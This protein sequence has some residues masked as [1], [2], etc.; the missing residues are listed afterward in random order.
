MRALFG[1]AASAIALCAACLGNGAADSLRVVV[2]I[3][4]VSGIVQPLLPAGSTVKVLMAP[5]RSEHNYEFTPADMAAVGGADLVVFVGAGLEPQVAKFLASH[6]SPKRV[7]LNLAD[8]SGIKLE[9]ED[10]HDHKHEDSDH[11]H[12]GMDP[13]VW[14]DPVLVKEALPR[15]AKA[16]QAAM[17]SR[18]EWNDGAKQRLDEALS[19][20]LKQ[21]DELNRAYQ[22]RLG[23]FK[24]EKIVTHHAAF[25]RLAARYGLVVAEVIRMNEG[26]EP[27]PGRIA[28]IVQA[29]RNEGVRT[30]FVEP[31]FDGATAERI[32]KAAGVKVVTMDPLGD[33]D[34][35]AMMRGNLDALMKGLHP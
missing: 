33:G 25:G 31:Q 29:V 35:F 6:P 34:W 18:G 9:D 3:P 27:T 17:E 4:P 16:V 30:I 26:E 15:L 32:A 5:G 23:P 2:T 1:W 24:G 28:A 7:D 19:N 21:V 13:H 8:A 14:L 22:E 12:G 20:E 10:K 11:D